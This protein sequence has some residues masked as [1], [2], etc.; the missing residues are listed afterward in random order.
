MHLPSVAIL[1]ILLFVVS[2]NDCIF[3][4]VSIC[5]E[6]ADSFF[7]QFLQFKYLSLVD[8]TDILSNF[9]SNSQ[10]SLPDIEAGQVLIEIKACGLAAIR[11]D[12]LKELGLHTS[13]A[14]LGRDVAGVVT[15]GVYIFLDFFSILVWVGFLNEHI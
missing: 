12:I 2:D 8:S 10:A 15:H 7:L 3:L 5:L 11:V 6:M 4:C 1:R 13:K 14:P 9:S